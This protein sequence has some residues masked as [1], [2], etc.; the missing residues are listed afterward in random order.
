MLVGVPDRAVKLDREARDRYGRVRAARLD[1]A[2]CSADRN[3]S[4]F[5]RLERIG[6]ARGSELGLHAGVHGPVLQCLEAPDRF[7]ELDACLQVLEGD[8]ECA[9][10]HAEQLCALRDPRRI[11]GVVDRS[12]RSVARS[13]SI[14]KRD[15]DLDE[16]ECA[17]RRPIDAPLFRQLDARLPGGHPEET[18][19]P[20][21]P[22]IHDPSVRAAPGHDELLFAVDQDLLALRRRLRSDLRR[23]E[24]TE[25]LLPRQSRDRAPRRDALEQGIA[26]L[27]LGHPA[28]CCNALHPGADEGL[29]HQAAAHLLSDC[30]SFTQTQ[31]QAALL[32]G[33]E[34][35]EP[36]GLGDL[37]PDGP[38]ECRARRAQLT[39]PLELVGAAEVILRAVAKGLDRIGSAHVRSLLVGRA[40]RSRPRPGGAPRAGPPGCARPAAAAACGTRSGCPR[41]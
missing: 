41:T 28:E 3:L 25:L 9:P 22:C 16:A 29:G 35:G 40:R 21:F 32:L 14:R 10:G 34:D 33:N 8:L 17:E 1:P 31:A 12:A 19:V 6:D 11:V 13:E 5:E 23:L 4:T 36:A 2:R 26:Q 39:E 24:L 38:L 7:A 20:G 37:L 27:A 18:R 15:R 30:R